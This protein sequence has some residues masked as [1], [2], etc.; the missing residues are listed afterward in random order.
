MS[1][2]SAKLERL[3]RLTPQ[4]LWLLSIFFS[5]AVTELIV[6]CMERILIGKISYDYLVTGFV[7]SL[8][9][10]GGVAAALIIL[11]KQLRL[12]VQCSHEL[13][14][15]LSKSEERRKLAEKANHQFLWDYEV[16]TGNVY[17]SEGWSQLLGDAPETT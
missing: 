9:V 15:E 5:I 12:E 1:D 4:G 17:L 6:S 2:L 13:A 3:Q 8:F 10:A 7:A 11:L 14:K 16:G